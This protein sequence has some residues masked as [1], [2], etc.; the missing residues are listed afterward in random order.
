MFVVMGLRWE[1]GRDG[2]ENWWWGRDDTGRMVASVWLCWNGEDGWAWRARW[3][4]NRPPGALGI[5]LG[6]DTTIVAEG[7]DDAATA[8][9]AV[10][11][12]ITAP[13]KDPPRQR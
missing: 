5:S 1:Q 9:A 8:M 12:H 2:D 11:A 3:W 7:L 10:D 13:R 6:R 4:G